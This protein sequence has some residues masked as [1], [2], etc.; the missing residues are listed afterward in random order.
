MTNKTSN[1]TTWTPMQIILECIEGP[2][3]MVHGLYKNRATGFHVTPISILANRSTAYVVFEPA[4]DC[5]NS[6]P[7]REEYEAHFASLSVKKFHKAY[8]FVG[9]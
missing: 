9:L 8:E 3:V 7:A 4:F 6:E 1:R 5:G 2:R